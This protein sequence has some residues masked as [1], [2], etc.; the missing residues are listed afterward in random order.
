ML[1]TGLC[2]CTAVFEEMFDLLH[3][4]TV[5]RI[6]ENLWKGLTA[7]RDLFF[8]KNADNMVYFSGVHRAV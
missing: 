1:K 7:L 6:S 8:S 4:L 2:L 3:S 5:V